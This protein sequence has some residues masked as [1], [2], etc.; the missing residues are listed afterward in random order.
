MIYVLSKMNG[1]GFPTF[2]HIFLSP[3]PFKKKNLA[4][5][6]NCHDYK[7]NKINGLDWTNYVS[8]YKQS[9]SEINTHQRKVGDNKKTSLVTLIGPRHQESQVPLIYIYIILLFI[10]LDLALSTWISW[11]LSSNYIWRLEVGSYQT[12]NSL[13]HEQRALHLQPTCFR[14]SY[15]ALC[16][17]HV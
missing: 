11:C 2:T 9:K 1:F 8:D 12:Q 14:F 13:F 5:Y 7:F 4:K 16:S 6:I 10:H 17:S 3:L 15:S